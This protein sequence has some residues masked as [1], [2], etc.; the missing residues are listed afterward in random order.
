MTS[1]GRLFPSA[2]PTPATAGGP[3]AAR[4]RA[5]RPE[6]QGLQP[7]PQLQQARRRRPRLW[8]KCTDIGGGGGQTCHKLTCKLGKTTMKCH[9]KLQMSTSSMKTNVTNRCSALQ[10][11][12]WYLIEPLLLSNMS[13]YGGYVSVRVNTKRQNHKPREIQKT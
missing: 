13:V 1:L 10:R 11:S 8:S 3:A 6:A 7:G 2:S 12:R 9:Q 4:R 5:L